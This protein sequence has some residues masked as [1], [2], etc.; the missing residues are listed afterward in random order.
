MITLKLLDSVADIEKNI[1]Q[2]IADEVN[3]RLLKNKNTILVKSKAL[4][5]SWILSQPE[6]NSLQSGE[7]A[8]QLGLYPGQ[9]FNSTNAIINSVENSIVI[10]F[11]KFSPKLVGGLEVQFQPSNFLN[12][13][14]LPQGFVN[15]SGGSLHWLEWLLIKG[16]SVIVANYQY[17]PQTGLGRSGLGNM[18]EGGFF[19]IPPQFSGIDS[20]NFITRALIGTQQEKQISQ[21]FEDILGV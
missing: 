13:L 21:I 6:I 8:G 16:D 1:N 3:S 11:K 4:V 17:N 10:D 5:S 19:R 2:A 20:D 7:L 12:L 14:N 15:Y 9:S 18:I